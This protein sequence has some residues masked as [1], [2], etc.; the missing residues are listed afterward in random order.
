MWGR[1]RSSVLLPLQATCSLLQVFQSF[2][3]FLNLLCRLPSL[4][5]LCLAI[6]DN[7]IDVFDECFWELVPE[8]RFSCDS[9]PLRIS[10]RGFVYLPCCRRSNCSHFVHEGMASSNF[11]TA[12][13]ISFHGDERTSRCASQSAVNCKLKSGCASLQVRRAGNKFGR[14][15]NFQSK[16]TLL[17]HGRL[18][19]A[20]RDVVEA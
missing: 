10:P 5:H 18:S 16:F 11:E 14:F 6:G 13:L 4:I 17:Y 7:F 19:T 9:H 2:T 12:C 8:E 1:L 15:E 3:L 20:T